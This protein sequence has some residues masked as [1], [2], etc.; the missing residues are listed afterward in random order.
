MWRKT[1]ILDRNDL[2]QVI[3]QMNPEFVFHMAARTDLGGQS[4]EEYAANTEGVANVI[5]ALSGIN[6]LRCAVFASSMLVCQ[7]GYKPKSETDYCP[8]TP[9]G[10]SKVVG[11]N[12]LRRIGASKFPWIIVRPTSI[13]GPWFEIPYRNF[14]TA[15]QHGIYIHPRKI[16]VRRSYGF[17]LNS[18][19]QL[20]KLIT[21]EH[22]GLVGHS[23]YLSDYEPIELK[24]W[25]HLIQESFGSRAIRE[26]PLWAFQFFAKIG[27]MLKYIGF[28][29]PP[30][31]STRLNNML[32]EMIHDVSL[33]QS[34]CGDVPYTMGE[35]V[36]LTCDWMKAHT[37]GNK[38]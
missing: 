9:Y 35:G 36:K 1:N 23:L 13:W 20:N 21:S 22:V 31:S 17:V 11:E 3:N 27:D 32:T 26:M 16:K 33:L 5:E 19:F 29:N 14:F 8:N 7:I 37:M 38:V 18:V 34:V 30:I 12:L 10:E 6:T 25:A 2:V 4:I 28:N 24:N 15:I